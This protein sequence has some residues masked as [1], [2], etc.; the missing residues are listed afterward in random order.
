MPAADVNVPD[1]P[2]V[3]AE[4]AEALP[5]SP[6]GA[7]PV[8]AVEVAPPVQALV[9]RDGGGQQTLGSVLFISW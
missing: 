4:Q 1:V 3:P 5:V 7:A 8:L 9:T 6:E 2:P